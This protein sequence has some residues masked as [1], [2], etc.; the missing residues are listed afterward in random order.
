MAEVKNGFAQKI[1]ITL[2]AFGIPSTFGAVWW[3]A[4][5]AAKVEV[6]QEVLE[7]QIED[8]KED[9]KALL[10]VSKKQS[11]NLTKLTT[12]VEERSKKE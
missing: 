4:K 2:L 11:E 9:I 8:N 3:A 6:Q 1:I 10:E 7:K 5:T 12:I